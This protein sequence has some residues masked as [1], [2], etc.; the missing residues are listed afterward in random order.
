MT[1]QQVQIR[2]ATK[3]DVN[4]VFSVWLRSYKHDSP[5][6]KNIFSDIFYQ[7]HQRHLDQ[8]LSNPQTQVLVAVDKQDPSLIFGFFAF[9][10]IQKVLDYVY[11]KKPFRR[12]GIGRALL[13]VA[14]ETLQ[15]DGW[16]TSHLTYAI[17]D[18]LTAKQRSIPFNPYLLAQERTP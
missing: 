3:D 7:Y 16:Q 12:F 13:S 5:V 1:N 2:K 8:I 14:D 4:F 11:I 15:F 10:P 17:L 9:R 6:T 18:V